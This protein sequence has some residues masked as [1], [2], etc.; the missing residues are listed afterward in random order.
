MF[1]GPI[2][3]NQYL[4]DRNTCYG[5]FSYFFNDIPF[6]ALDLTAVFLDRLELRFMPHFSLP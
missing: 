2:A 5:L 4:Q 3:D 6:V 1:P